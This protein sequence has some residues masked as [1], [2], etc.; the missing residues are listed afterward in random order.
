M[1]GYDINWSASANEKV[2]QHPLYQKYSSS[3]FDAITVSEVK[4]DLGNVIATTGSTAICSYLA[5]LIRIKN[6]LV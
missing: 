5:W 3:T 2:L 1:V 4:N 6:L